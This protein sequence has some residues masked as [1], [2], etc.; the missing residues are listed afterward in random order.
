MT[1][2]KIAEIRARHDK[3]KALCLKDGN[4]MNDEAVFEAVDDREWLLEEVDGLRADLEE[5][6][7]E[8]GVADQMAQHIEELQQKI[9]TEKSCA[10]S[11]DAP[12][13]VCVAHSPAL[14]EARAEVER[15]KE[16]LLDVW[17]TSGNC[18]HSAA[19]DRAEIERLRYVLRKI[20]SE[21]HF[22]DECWGIA[23]KA[24][25]VAP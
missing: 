6:L 3:F 23:R 19:L 14:A 13:D 24:L 11:F 12:G 18:S 15:L 8:L 5:A 2:D 21:R 10:C 22:A 20:A 7:D 25:E 17:A 9:D 1:N 16:K 4:Y